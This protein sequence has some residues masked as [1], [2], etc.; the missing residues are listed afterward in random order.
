MVPVAAN[1]NAEKVIF[2]DDHRLPDQTKAMDYFEDIFKEFYGQD[3][4]SAY[5]TVAVR[6][7]PKTYLV[8]ERN[9]NPC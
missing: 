9:F 4:V 1:Q 8:F 6:C 7:T 2:I 3:I 5:L